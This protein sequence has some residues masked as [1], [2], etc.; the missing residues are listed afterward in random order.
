MIQFLIDLVKSILDNPIYHN[1][2]EAYIKEGNP[3]NVGDVERLEREF[4]I[5]RQHLSRYW[6]E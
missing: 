6:T 4:S 2:L 5:Q 1:D 3:Q